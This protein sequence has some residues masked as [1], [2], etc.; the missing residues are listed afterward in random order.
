[1]LNTPSV[2]MSVGA[3]R[4]GRGEALSGGGVRVP[5][6]AQLRAAQPCAV[7]QRGVAQAIEQHLLGAPG[8]CAHDGEVGHVAGGEQQRALA[9]GEFGQLLLEAG[10]L[11]AVPGDQVR[12][13]AAGARRAAHSPMARASAGWRVSPR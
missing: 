6:T 12:G 8:E 13:A 10:V 2:A 7:D 11:G 3:A 9:L 1:M 4:G 5:V